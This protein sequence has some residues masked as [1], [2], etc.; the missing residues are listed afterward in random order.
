MSDKTPSAIPDKAQVL[1]AIDYHSKQLRLHKR[2]LK[3]CHEQEEL[4]T[5][6]APSSEG[7]E[8]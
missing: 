6:K 1:L 5:G 4:Q 7:E 2:Q 3:L 8:S